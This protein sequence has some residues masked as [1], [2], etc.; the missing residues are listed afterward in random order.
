MGPLCCSIWGGNIVLL[1]NI[2]GLG[3][4]ARSRNEGLHCVGI[5]I[6]FGWLVCAQAHPC[7]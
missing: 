4:A 3:L 2:F 7:R 1:V 6:R 5:L